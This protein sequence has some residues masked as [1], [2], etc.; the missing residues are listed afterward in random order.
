MHCAICDTDSD[1]VTP[2]TDCAVCQ[3]AIQECL[4]GYPRLD[5]D[6]VENVDEDFDDDEAENYL[7]DIGTIEAREFYGS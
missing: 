4:D 6:E 7:I 1:T 2:T 5:E 3:E